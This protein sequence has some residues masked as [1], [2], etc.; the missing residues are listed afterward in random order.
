MAKGGGT[1]RGPPSTGTEGPRTLRGDSEGL[2]V[3]MGLGAPNEE[4]AWDQGR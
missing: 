2:G 3:S 4:E 1:E